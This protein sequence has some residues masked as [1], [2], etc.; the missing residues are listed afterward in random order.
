VVE[1]LHHVVG[2]VGARA[3]ADGH[4]RLAVFEAEHALAGDEA[5][6]EAGVLLLEAH[7]HG[8]D[9]RRD[10]GSEVTT[11]SPVTSSPRPLMRET[12]CANWSSVACA[13]WRRSSPASVAV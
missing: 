6:D 7:E 2:L 5:H 8:R 1:G 4:M 9:E 11:S 3:R 13:T 10:G 12:S